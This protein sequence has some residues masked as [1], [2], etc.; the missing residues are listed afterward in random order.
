MHCDRFWAPKGF[1]VFC[2]VDLLSLDSLLAEESGFWGPYKL[3]RPGRILPREPWPLKT[4]FK[5]IE[6]LQAPSEMG[7]LATPQVFC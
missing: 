3:R 6:I 5:G 7:H 4:I 2:A 1:V